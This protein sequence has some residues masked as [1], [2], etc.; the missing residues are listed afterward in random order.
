M[1]VCAKAKCVRQTRE[2]KQ[3]H[4]D[5]P[6]LFLLSCLGIRMKIEEEEERKEIITTTTGE[7]EE[8]KKETAYYNGGWLMSFSDDM[9][10]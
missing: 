6:S 3:K 8:K 5:Y 2:R 10:Y 4:T 7:R 1:C 9:L